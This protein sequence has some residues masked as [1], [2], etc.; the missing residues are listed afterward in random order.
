MIVQGNVPPAV[1][2]A[3]RGSLAVTIEHGATCSS[4]AGAIT[5]GETAVYEWDQKRH[6][7]PSRAHTEGNGRVGIRHRVCPALAAPAQAHSETSLE[8]AAKITPITPN[9]RDRVER[10]LRIW[11]STDEEGATTLGI[12]L[13]TYRPRRVELVALSKVHDSGRTRKTRSGSDATIW[14]ITEEGDHAT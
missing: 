10:H 12:E 14:E 1:L 8:A 7:Q 4:C 11:P 6:A 3:S 5:R 13:N 2:Y 9:L